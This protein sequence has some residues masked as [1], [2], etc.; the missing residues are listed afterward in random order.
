[1][2]SVL[3]WIRNEPAM[4]VTFALVILNTFW[5]VNAEQQIQIQLVIE[6]VLLLIGGK[7]IRDQVT[8]VAKLN[9]FIGE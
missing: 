1:V 7:A 6:N 2:K 8:P 4:I 3:N 5:T 9:P